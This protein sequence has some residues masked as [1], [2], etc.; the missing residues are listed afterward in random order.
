MYYICTCYVKLKGKAEIISIIGRAS[1]TLETI[2]KNVL[3]A[4]VNDF[5]IM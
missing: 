2:S 3:S 5:R 4:I 1:G